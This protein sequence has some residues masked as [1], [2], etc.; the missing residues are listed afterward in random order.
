MNDNIFLLEANPIFQK[1]SLLFMA[2]IV[3]IISAAYLNSFSGVW[4]FD[5]EKYLLD[6][7]AVRQVWPP[8]YIYGNTRPILFF[9]FAINYAL[10][11]YDIFFFHVTNLVVHIITALAVFLMVRLTLKSKR[12]KESFGN[13][14]DHLALISSLIWGVQPVNT[15]AV[16]YIWQRGESLMAM[17]YL[18]TIL[19][20]IKSVN[21]RKK[22]YTVLSVVACFMGVLSKEVM[23]SAPIVVLLYDWFFVAD[24]F[25]EIW[26]KRKW[27]YFSLVI[28][29][30]V[31]AVLSAGCV[32]D[33]HSN[34]ALGFNSLKFTPFTYL[35]NMPD[36]YLQYFRLS[37]FPYFLCFDYGFKTTENI[38]NVIPQIFCAFLGVTAIIYG[39]YKKKLWS[40]PFACFFLVLAPTS[41]IMPM[42]DPLIEYRIYLPLVFLMTFYVL[43]GYKCTKFA[44]NKLCHDAGKRGFIFNRIFFGCA[45]V[46]IIIFS[47]FTVNRNFVYSNGIALWSDVV[48]KFPENKRAQYNLGHL[49]VESGRAKEALKPLH[50]ALELDPDDYQIYLNIGNAFGLLD[51][52]ERAVRSYRKAVELNPEYTEAYNNLGNSLVAL[53]RFNEAF[54]QYKKALSRSKTPER[55]YVNIGCAFAKLKEYTKAIE[56]FDYAIRISPEYAE[57][58]Y[59]LGLA[60]RDT[61]DRKNALLSLSKALELNPEF[62]N[63]RK[64]ISSI[65]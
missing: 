56:N 62:D 47:L 32:Q 45:A 4:V 39:I 21:T 41:S 34:K 1:K 18:F 24:D 58:Y 42:P 50:K 29:W 3:V 23:V 44:C 30:G 31:L 16:T 5:D 57:A 28:S 60:Y 19:F 54:E 46:L 52:H 10:G 9:T 43:A 11:H 65:K 2:I 15:M 7:N 48:Y 12:L 55:V 37:I 59:N 40:F 53:G 51:K 20:F 33:F 64:A 8:E 36:V 13:A 6:N 63:A 49:L 38:S 26:Q 22:V 35:I 25:K 17:F 14:A 27:Y 61:G